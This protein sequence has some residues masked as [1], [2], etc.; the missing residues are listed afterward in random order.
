[1]TLVDAQL[2]TSHYLKQCWPWSISPRGLIKPQ[3]FNRVPA[4]NTNN[5]LTGYSYTET[6]ILSCW[7]F[8]ITGCVGGYNNL[9]CTRVI[10]MINMMTFPFECESKISKTHIDVWRC[11]FSLTKHKAIPQT[12]TTIRFHY[13][14]LCC[15]LK[16]VSTS[17]IGCDAITCFSWGGI[18]AEEP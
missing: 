13:S 16:D 2:A 5:Y 4:T 14:R 3:W 15:W 9:R 1:M 6:E 18:D 11:Y 10:K 17:L 7:T 8:F 12:N